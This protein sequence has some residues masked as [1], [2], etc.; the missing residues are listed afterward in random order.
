MTD[1]PG[2]DEV[3]STIADQAAVYQARQ[4]LNRAHDSL[5]D[6]AYSLPRWTATQRGM[7]QELVGAMQDVDNALTNLE[8]PHRFMRFGPRLDRTDD[9]HRWREDTPF[10]SNPMLRY[11]SILLAAAWGVAFGYFIAGRIL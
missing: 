4:F 9:G 7:R 2:T 5:R 8:L 11:M 6:L 3:L 10:W 1:D